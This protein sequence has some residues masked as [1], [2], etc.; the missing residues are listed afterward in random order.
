[1]YVSLRRYDFVVKVIKNGRR[2]IKNVE[3]E[4]NERSRVPGKRNQI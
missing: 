1:M 4:K 3:P 2:E